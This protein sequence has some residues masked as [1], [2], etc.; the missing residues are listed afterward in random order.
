MDARLAARKTQRGPAGLFSPHSGSPGA[1][2]RGR[3]PDAGRWTG[4]A[5]QAWQ[6][7]ALGME[8]Q[9][10]PQGPTD[11]L[12]WGPTEWHPTSWNYYVQYLSLKVPPTSPTSGYPRT[13]AS[14]SFTLGILMAARPYGISVA[15]PPKVE[16]PPLP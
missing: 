12:G 7:Q 13:R 4:S 2:T 14:L 15:D 1:L 10:P 5:W 11:C 3:L 8:G 16:F 6:G 9:R